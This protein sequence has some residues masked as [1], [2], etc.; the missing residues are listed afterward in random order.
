MA[1]KHITTKLSD[2]LS[3]IELVEFVH[4]TSGRTI[5]V[6]F[7]VWDDTQQC[8]IVMYAKTKDSALIQAI[9]YHQRYHVKIQNEFTELKDKVDSF[10]TSVHPYDND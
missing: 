7:W 4:P 1:R 2:T 5:P 9:M 10:I 6:E 8:N 3:L